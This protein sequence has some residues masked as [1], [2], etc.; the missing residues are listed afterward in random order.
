VIVT[1][2]IPMESRAC[3]LA[4]LLQGADGVPVYWTKSDPCRVH[5]RITIYQFRELM[6]INGRM[7]NWSSISV[8]KS[9]DPADRG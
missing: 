7:E 1:I 8:I 4:W 6:K 2:F 9:R 5:T 3:K